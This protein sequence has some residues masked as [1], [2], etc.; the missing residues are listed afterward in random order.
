[1]AISH[2]GFD[3]LMKMDN[4]MGSH[5]SNFASTSAPGIALVA[6]SASLVIDLGAYTSHVR[7]LNPSFLLIWII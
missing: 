6:L 7:Y 2:E 5:F 1:M 4:F 3:C